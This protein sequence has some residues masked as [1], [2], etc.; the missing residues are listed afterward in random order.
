[1]ASSKKRVT[2]INPAPKK[3]RQIET[4]GRLGEGDRHPFQVTAHLAE[5]VGLDFQSPYGPGTLDFQTNPVAAF[6]AG[7][8]QSRPK[9]SVAYNQGFQNAQTMVGPH[10]I[11]HPG[12][13]QEGAA[14]LALCED[15]AVD[16]IPG[17]G[18][19]LLFRCI[20]VRLFFY[21]FLG[22]SAPSKFERITVFKTPGPAC[23][24]IPPAETATFNTL[25]DNSGVWDIS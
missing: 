15:K 8:H 6:Q 12:S 17:T 11:H 14:N 23:Q 3:G 13:V 4:L 10:F 16:P 22:G 5:G 19:V 18:E 25:F 9:I 1:L 21:H 20:S 24:C 2:R 7:G